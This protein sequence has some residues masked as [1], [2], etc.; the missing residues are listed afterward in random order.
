MQIIVCLQAYTAADSYMRDCWKMNKKKHPAVYM[1]AGCRFVDI[2]FLHCLYIG[3]RRA[4]LT[5][6]NIE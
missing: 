5:L 6:L 1:A 4:F 3:S 2:T